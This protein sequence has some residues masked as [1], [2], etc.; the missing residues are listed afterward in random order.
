VLGGAPTATLHI[1][2]QRISTSRL[3]NRPY[4]LVSIRILDELR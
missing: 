1:N 3:R 2:G 4:R